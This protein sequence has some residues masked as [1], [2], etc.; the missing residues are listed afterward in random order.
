MEKRGPSHS[1]AVKVTSPASVT[2]VPDARPVRSKVF[3]AGTV[4]KRRGKSLVSPTRKQGLELERRTKDLMVMLSW[5][6]KRVS[7]GKK[8]GG[9][10]E[11]GQDGRGAFLCAVE[12][13]PRIERSA[14]KLEQSMQVGQ[15]RTRR[16]R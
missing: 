1:A 7:E 14:L 2:L 6:V 9:Q 8:L 11:G 10:V 3:F 4:W 15:T 5:A 16:R 13:E 12:A